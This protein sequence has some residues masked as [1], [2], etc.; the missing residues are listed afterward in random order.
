MLFI[1]ITLKFIY[2]ITKN[3]NNNIYLLK[4]LYKDFFPLIYK[5]IIINMNN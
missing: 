2:I 1:K 3:N 5:T 4:F